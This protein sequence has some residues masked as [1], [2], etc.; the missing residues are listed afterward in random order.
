M[1]FLKR[2][3]FALLLFLMNEINQ[4]KQSEQLSVR[5]ES[6]LTHWISHY[7]ISLHS[8]LSMSFDRS[9][10][11]TPQMKHISMGTPVFSSWPIPPVL[12]SQY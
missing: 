6:S 7:Q 8:Y 10:S 1:Q 12:A 9:L 4:L 3:L 11:L 2:S 5:N